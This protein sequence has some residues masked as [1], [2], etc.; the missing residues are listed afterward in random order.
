LA[1]GYSPE[2][3]ALLGTFIHGHAGDLAAIHIGQQALLASDIID[4]LGKAFLNFENHDPT[5]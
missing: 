5:F 3:A 4:Y 2:Q 1:Q